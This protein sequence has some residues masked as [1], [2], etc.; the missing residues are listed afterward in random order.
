MTAPTTLRPPAEWAAPPAER[1]VG[2]A[3][4]PPPPE[5]DWPVSDAELVEGF[6]FAVGHGDVPEVTEFIRMQAIAAGARLASIRDYEGDDDISYHYVTSDGGEMSVDRMRRLE[7]LTNPANWVCD[8][9]SETIL[10]HASQVLGQPTP[11]GM[12]AKTAETYRQARESLIATVG[13]VVEPLGYDVE[14]SAGNMSRVV[15]LSRYARQELRDRGVDVDEQ[16]ASRRGV[17]AA[18]PGPRSIHDTLDMSPIDYRGR[19]TVFKPRELV[20]DEDK[21]EEIPDPTVQ[22]EQA[23]YTTP[24]GDSELWRE[25]EVLPDQ[26][27]MDYFLKH[28]LGHRDAV[29]HLWHRMLRRRRGALQ[30]M[31]TGGSRAYGGAGLIGSARRF[32]N[33]IT[34]GETAG[35]GRRKY[36]R[37]SPEQQAQAKD[38]A[39]RL[40]VFKPFERQVE[41]GG[42]VPSIGKLMTKM[43]PEKRGELTADERATVQT[44]LERLQRVERYRARPYDRD[45][46]FGYTK[47]GRFFTEEQPN[48]EASTPRI[49]T[50]E[51]QFEPGE[52]AMTPSGYKEAFRTG[53][54]YTPRDLRRYSATRRR[55]LAPVRA[56]SR[57]F[58][59][60]R[61]ALS[62]VLDDPTQTS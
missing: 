46:R 18:K 36:N 23:E 10:A 40:K 27:V 59:G 6:E 1:Y 57:L 48:P 47:I 45:E 33:W 26:V 54:T 30:S 55:M 16:L 60:R 44:A 17:G 41:R 25:G 22:R 5:M 24:L 15:A 38:V 43:Y 58:G 51:E 14:V 34:T 37:L 4:A 35:G 32:A 52:L 20:Y 61:P 62:T 3:A 53:L 28:G 31:I 49:T 12:N 56:V 29:P 50:D 21:G 2:V 9:V 42:D 39:R 13:K 11:Q 19:A 7:W 8:K